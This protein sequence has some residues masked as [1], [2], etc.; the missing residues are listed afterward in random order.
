MHDGFEWQDVRMICGDR[1]FEVFRQLRGE[2]ASDATSR[3]RLLESSLDGE[4]P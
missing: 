4:S 3:G 1:V 2:T